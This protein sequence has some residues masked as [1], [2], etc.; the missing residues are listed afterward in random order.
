MTADLAGYYLF[1]GIV[2]VCLIKKLLWIQ[3]DRNFHRIVYGNKKPRI[4]TRFT[5]TYFLWQV[6]NDWKASWTRM[7]YPPNY[8]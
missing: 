4:W 8:I 6:G 1:L 3:G 2:L 5:A 7:K